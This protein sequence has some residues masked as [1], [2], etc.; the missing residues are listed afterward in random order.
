VGCVPFTPDY[1]CCDDWAD[2]T[3]ELQERATDLAWSTIRTLSGSQIGNCP[4]TVRPCLSEAC[5]ACSP[6]AH[7]WMTPSIR[8]GEWVNSACG[9]HRCSCERMCEIVVPSSV[10]VIAQV[11]L[12][13]TELPLED[14]RVD[15]GNRIVRQDGGCW[16]SCQNMTAPLGSPGT[17][18]ITYVPGIVPS[19]AGLWAVGVLACEFSKACTRGKCRLP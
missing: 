10:A 7:Q 19:A 14:F 3:P 16:P 17:L 13:G 12:D 6:W 1:S 5:S 9:S 11:L 4:T 15:N 18:G 2:L 8:A